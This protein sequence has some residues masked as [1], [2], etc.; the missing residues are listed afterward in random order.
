MGD[1]RVMFCPSAFSCLILF[2]SRYFCL[3]ILFFLVCKDLWVGDVRSFFLLGFLL[4]LLT[5]PRSA[6]DGGGFSGLCL[7]FEILNILSMHEEVFGALKL[8]I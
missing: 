8:R 5:K 7:I 3:I 4:V 1:V 2:F 6:N